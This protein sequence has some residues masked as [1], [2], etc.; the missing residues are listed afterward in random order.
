MLLDADDH[1]AMVDALGDTTMATVGAASFP[2]VL[3]RDAGASLA[4][5]MLDHNGPYALAASADVEALAMAVGNNG[6]TITINGADYTLLAI[7][8][9]GSG[10]S[11]LLLQETA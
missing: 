6:D 2:V 5:E 7:D 1:R 8:H 4:G 9:D 11:V 10:A 3:S